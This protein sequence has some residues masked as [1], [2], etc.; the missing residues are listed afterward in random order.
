MSHPQNLWP[1]ACCG[2]PTEQPVG[3]FSPLPAPWLRPQGCGRREDFLLTGPA[4]SVPSVSLVFRK[5]GAS[6]SVGHNHLLGREP[7]SPKRRVGD[8]SEGGGQHLA[9]SS[10]PAPS[11]SWLFPPLTAS[12]PWDLGQVSSLPGFHR[13]GSGWGTC[14]PSSKAAMPKGEPRLRS[15]WPDTGSPS[16]S[17]ETTIFLLT[18]EFPSFSDSRMP[19]WQRVWQATV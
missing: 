1:E 4:V 12:S 8:T 9:G 16:C 6:S 11:Q 7:T 3:A 19:C 10:W 2:R 13:P 17:R 15:V 14:S 5:T 18:L